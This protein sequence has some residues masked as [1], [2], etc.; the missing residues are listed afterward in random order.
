M[1]MIRLSGVIDSAGVTGVV[2]QCD[3]GLTGIVNMN[4][5]SKLLLIITDNHLAVF[6]HKFSKTGY[7]CA[8]C[9]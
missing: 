5:S 6:D 9:F 3:T 8:Y 7:S 1:R 4:K 2:S